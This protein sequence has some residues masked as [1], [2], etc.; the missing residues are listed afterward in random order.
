MLLS[1]NNLLSQVNGKIRNQN[2]LIRVNHFSSWETCQYYGVHQCFCLQMQNH[3]HLAQLTYLCA[4]ASYLNNDG[5]TL[6]G[7]LRRLRF[8]KL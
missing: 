1:P 7:S 2:V 4:H 8:L 5:G 6:E 3:R